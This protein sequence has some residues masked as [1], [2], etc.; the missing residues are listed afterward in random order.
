MNNSEGM[1]AAA[2]PMPIAELARRD[3]LAAIAH[4][5]SVTARNPAN[6]GAH[7]MLGRVLRTLGRD[8]EAAAAEMS[9]IRATTRDPEMIAIAQAMMDSDLAQAE[10]GLRARLSAQPLDVAAIRMMAELAGRLGRYKDAENLLRRAI[11]LAPS[12]TA[13]QANL[14]MALYKQNRYGEASAVLEQVLARDPVN[15]GNRNLLAATL[16]RIGD[17]DEALAIYGELVETFPDHAKLW[18][19]YGHMLK[20]VGQLE[21]SIAAYRRALAAEPHLG[22]VWWSLANLKTITFDD[23][24]IAAMEAA[25]AAGVSSDD[26]L[27]L[28]FALGKAYADRSEVA[29]SFRHYDA[30]NALRSEELGYEPEVITQQ[31]DRMIEVLTPEF[32]AQKQGLGD[33]T[34]DPIFILGLPRAGSTLLEQILSSHSQIEGTMELPDIPAM[35]MREAKAAGNDLRDWPDAVADMPAERFAELGAEFLER[36]RVQ[37]KTAKPFYIDKLPNNWSYAGFIH[38]ILPNAKIIDARRHPMDCCFSNFRQ[39]F[40]KGQAFSY[41]LD[42]IGRYYADYVRAMDHYDRVLPGR[43]HRVIHEQLLDDPEAEVR[44]M[45]GYLGLPF[46]DSCMEFHRNARAVRTASSE[47]VR[48]PINRDGVGQWEPYRA[49]L[50]PLE[51]ALGDLPQTYRR[52]PD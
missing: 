45:L 10:A 28:H 52:L 34:P 40:A 49:W 23:A 22:E 29:D 17:Y 4:L 51:E 46:E 39:H 43:V 24:D 33:Q 7:R 13:A 36:T 16:G 30:G 26:A 25:L 12:F 14:A 41:S 27:H 38:L 21:Q 9:A 1:Q 20:T 50:G 5:R 44:A 11:E 6:A 3:P 37:R 32:L 18:M 19:S 15:P 35:A 2:P 48:R 31:V 8:E 42:H 47:Q